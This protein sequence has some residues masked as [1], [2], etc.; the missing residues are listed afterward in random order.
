MAITMSHI[1]YGLFFLISTFV[2]SFG[3]A[4]NNLYPTPESIG[5]AAS[6]VRESIGQLE[7]NLTRDNLL[8]L[9]SRLKNF[10]EVIAIIEQS[11]DVDREGAAT[12]KTTQAVESVNEY[13]VDIANAL[14]AFRLDKSQELLEEGLEQAFEDLMVNEVQFP[15]LK[16]AFKL[17]RD[18]V[19][20]RSNVDGQVTAFDRFR[21]AINEVGRDIT[22]ILVGKN[23]TTNEIY[24]K[25]A[26]NMKRER[27]T[28]NLIPQYARLARFQIP[29]YNSL[30]DGDQ[31]YNRANHEERLAGLLI[32]LTDRAVNIKVERN[33]A[34]KYAV[35]FYATLGVILSNPYFNYL[36]NS[37]TAHLESSIIT[38]TTFAVITIFKF[39]MSSVRS[40]AEWI[41]FN[42]EIRSSM[43]DGLVKSTEIYLRKEFP[44]EYHPANVPHWVLRRIQVRNAIS[45]KIHQAFKFKS[46]Q[47][48]I[49]LF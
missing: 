19:D 10:K 8:S 9:Q 46:K 31:E 6:Q 40:T 23:R 20:E 39:M 4:D 48:C 2:I 24:H 7:E 45:K 44:T 28:L 5:F 49:G 43:A 13:G 41:Q 26:Q 33:S 3:F 1:R 47:M 27:S 37:Y 12:R 11:I 15:L 21:R 17:L 29:T 30:Y 42:Q 18:R 34:Q 32:W 16:L 35:I 22:D 36:G 25:W 38:A 14:F